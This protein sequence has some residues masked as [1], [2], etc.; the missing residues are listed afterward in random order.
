MTT[1]RCRTVSVH[2]TCELVEGAARIVGPK[3]A[4]PGDWIVYG[5]SKGP[6]IVPAKEF[7]RHFELLPE[8]SEDDPTGAKAL[9]RHVCEERARESDLV[10]SH[11]EGPGPDALAEFAMGCVEAF[12]ERVQTDLAPHEPGSTMACELCQNQYA[13]NEALAEGRCPH[14]GSDKVAPVEPEGTGERDVSVGY[15]AEQDRVVVAFPKSVRGLR[16]D[17]ARARAFATAIWESLKGK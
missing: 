6:M 13:E 14:C 15:D 1:R 4:M 2:S 11:P 16:M 10:P 7:S 17:P 12:L 8:P 9:A 3:T 5:D